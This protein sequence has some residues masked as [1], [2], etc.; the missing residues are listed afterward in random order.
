M[1]ESPVRFGK[2]GVVLAVL[3]MLAAFFAFVALLSPVGA[4]AAP[5]KQAFADT[6]DHWAVR[7]IERMHAK[8]L[9]KGVQ[10]PDGSLLFEPDRHVTRW[11]T[12]VMMVRAMGFDAQAKLRTSIPGTFKDSASVPAWARGYVGEAVAR[13]V[14]AGE[15]LVSF[16][17]DANAT[18]IEVAVWLVRALGLE[19]EADKAGASAFSD[20]GAVPA[21]R[22]GYITTVADIGLMKG[23]QGKFRPGD[24]IKRA[25]MATV[26]SRMDAMLDNAADFLEYSGTVEDVADGLQVKLS[27]GSIRAFAIAQDASLYF[28]DFRIVSLITGMVH[29]GDRVTLITDDGGKAA[30]VEVSSPVTRTSG[31][32]AAIKPGA[33]AALTIT[34]TLS[35]GSAKSF[36]LSPAAVIT[37]N[38][39]PAG[40]GWLAVGQ[41]ATIEAQGDTAQR[42]RAASQAVDKKGRIE[43]L[44]FLPDGQAIIGLLVKQP[45]GGTKEEVFTVEKNTPVTRNGEGTR[46]LYL[47]R[48]DLVTLRIQEGQVSQIRAQSEERTLKGELRAVIYGTSPEIT[49]ILAKGYEWAAD[50]KEGTPLTTVTVA[51]DVKV[52]KDGETAGL[53][54]LLP[55]DTLE[56]KLKGETAVS[57]SAETT[58]ASVEG[59]VDSIVIGDPYQITVKDSAGVVKTYRV[60]ADVSVRLGDNYVSLLSLKPGYRVTLQVAH[61][62]V[63]S[64]RGV[65]QATLDDIRGV[66]RYIDTAAN[67][68][69]VELAGAGSMRHAKPDG[70]F[71]V[72]R[73]GRIYE[74]LSSLKIGDFVIVV[75]KDVPGEPFSVNTVVITGVGG[76]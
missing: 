34:L 42:I 61:D 75:G 22:K 56:V 27:D 30:F 21:T 58:Y 10:R 19:G 4:A 45:D 1:R 62:Q 36:N 48:K 3:A 44:V 71:T 29:K 9:I 8:G 52:K 51:A 40:G 69:V 63:R 14:I 12:I 66:I 32:I 65:A 76:N 55:G 2:V 67:K 64:I 13:G 38:D 72:V 54:S 46:V 17:G 26:L 33:G 57:I 24:P 41:L 53:T 37:L 28:E 25:E 73:F 60:A 59:K 18:R 16:R 20:L 11:E 74:T 49:V 15:E 6:A 50:G 39:R 31:T 68:F 5:A 35:D 47:E 43:S 7:Y 70:D 23:D